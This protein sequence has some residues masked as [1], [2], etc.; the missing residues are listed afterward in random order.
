[1]TTVTPSTLQRYTDT[2]ATL[3]AKGISLVVFQSPCCNTAIKTLPAP[4]GASWD[5]TSQCPHCEAVYMK[6]TTGRS[7]K[8]LIPDAPA[9]RT[10]GGSK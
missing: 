2:I 6:I 4:E 5:S 1:M 8:G 10:V 9:T 7:A 3:E